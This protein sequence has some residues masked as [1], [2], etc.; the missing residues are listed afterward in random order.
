MTAVVRRLPIPTG[1]TAR[2]KDFDLKYDLDPRPK[3]R[4]DSST[5]VAMKIRQTMVVW[6]LI[7]VLAPSM[8]RAQAPSLADGTAVHVRLTADLLSSEVVV[9]SRVEMEVAQPVALQNEV[10]IPEGSVAWGVVQAVKSGKILD[11]EI[12]GARLPNGRIVLLRCSPQRATKKKKDEIKVE[13]RMGMDLGAPKG[14]EYTA[15][16]DQDLDVDLAREPLTPAQ[17][18]AVAVAAAEPTTPATAPAVEAVREAA[19]PHTPPPDTPSAPPA[20]AVAPPVAPNPAA[21]ARGTVA[22]LAPAAEPRGSTKI[23]CFSNPPGADILIDGEFHGSTPS[24]LKILP[25]YHQIEF[26]LIGYKPYVQTLNLP[27]SAGLHSLRTTLE[28]Q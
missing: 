12:V 5:G 2:D 18:S 4:R 28:K 7:A 3:I 26:R 1:A 17:P 15:Y 10:L 23:G 20:P 11:F 16:L 6:G 14:M 9:G 21:S 24:T 8:V 13:I 25:G 27:A 22:V 19:A